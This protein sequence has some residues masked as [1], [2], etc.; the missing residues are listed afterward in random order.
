MNLSGN[1]IADESTY[2]QLVGR[3][4]DDLVIEKGNPSDIYSLEGGGRVFEY[5]YLKDSM[6]LSQHALRTAHAQT[7]MN[8][9][10]RI[11]STESGVPFRKRKL[12]PNKECKIMFKVS[13]SDIIESWSTECEN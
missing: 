10:P 3:N 13:A 7:A 1:K 11:M 4:A 9:S 8:E 12:A 6:T 2:N 5:W